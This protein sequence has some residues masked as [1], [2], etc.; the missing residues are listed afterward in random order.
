MT[1]NPQGNKV[2]G[3]VCCIRFCNDFQFIGIYRG[4]KIH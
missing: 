1:D 4:I 2:L 3:I